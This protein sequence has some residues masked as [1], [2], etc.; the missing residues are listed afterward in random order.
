MLKVCLSGKKRISTTV[1]MTIS[2]LLRKRALMPLDI[3]VRQRGAGL[4]QQNPTTSIDL[5]LLSV[6]EPVGNGQKQVI[7]LQGL[8][9]AERLLIQGSI[10]T[11]GVVQQLLLG[12]IE[13]ANLCHLLWGH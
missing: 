9:P 4:L 5:F 8:H 3:S 7:L 1:N 6:S 11:A 13:L 10:A 2:R 12:W